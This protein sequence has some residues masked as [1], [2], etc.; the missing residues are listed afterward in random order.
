MLLHNPPD[1]FNFAALDIAPFE[2]MVATGKVLAYGVSCRTQK[3]VANVLSQGFGSVIEAVYNPL[4][5][6]YENYFSDPLYKDRYIFICRVPLASG[7]ISRAHYQPIHRSQL[8]IS[9]VHLAV[10][11]WNG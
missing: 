2:T 5:R 9:G 4:D 3:G 8:M 10:N 11:R 6:R 7:L 1:D